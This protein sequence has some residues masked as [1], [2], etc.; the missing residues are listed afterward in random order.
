M[1]TVIK[2]RSNASLHFLPE[3]PVSADSDTI[4]VMPLFCTAAVYLIEFKCAWSTDFLLSTSS[5]FLKMRQEHVHIHIFMFRH[6]WGHMNPVT[7]PFQA[8]RSWIKDSNL[9]ELHG[10]EILSSV[11]MCSYHS[12]WIGAFLKLNRH[13]RFK[14]V[15]S[16]TLM[17]QLS[18]LSSSHSSALP[19]SLLQVNGFP[20]SIVSTLCWSQT[21]LTVH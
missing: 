14:L 19:P 18:L 7:N 8:W 9:R 2:H 5:I 20:I 11:T 12:I 10:S 3:L 4:T 15:T 16:R 21:G 13:V 17:L 1:N 6:I